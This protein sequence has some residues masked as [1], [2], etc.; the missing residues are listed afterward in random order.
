MSNQRGPH[1]HKIKIVD[2]TYFKIHYDNREVKLIRWF[3]KSPSKKRIDRAIRN[4]VAWH[5][6]MALSE[7]AQEDRLASM[8]KHYNTRLTTLK[9]GYPTKMTEWGSAVLNRDD[10]ID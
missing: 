5:D 9:S 7:M 6:R 8:Q 1:T 10:D 4:M 3:G 2:S